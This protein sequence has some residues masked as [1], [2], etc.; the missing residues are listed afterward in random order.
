MSLESNDLVHNSRDERFCIMLHMATSLDNFKNNLKHN[1]LIATFNYL[2]SFLKL[3]LFLTTFKIIISILSSTLHYEY[4][5]KN[6]H[7]PFMSMIFI[8]IQIKFNIH[9]SNEL[10]KTKS[11]H[12]KKKKIVDCH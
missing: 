8:L 6:Q 5:K 7:V 1:S 10:L 2:N 3:S 4:E 12:K 11:K 9:I